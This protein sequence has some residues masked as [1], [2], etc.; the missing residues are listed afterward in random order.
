MFRSCFCTL[1]FLKMIYILY[2]LKTHAV[3]VSSICCPNGKST[4][5]VLIGKNKH[6]KNSQI[7]QTNSNIHL[8]AL[9]AQNVLFQCSLY[10]FTCKQCTYGTKFCS[11][12]TIEKVKKEKNVCEYI[13]VIVHIKLV[14]I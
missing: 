3:I 7:A 5:T 12:S 9:L 1:M 10:F 2:L 4:R 6:T 11:F 13:N 14:S 8:H